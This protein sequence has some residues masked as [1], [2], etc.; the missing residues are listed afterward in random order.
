MSMKMTFKDEGFDADGK[1]F[2]KTFMKAKG[3]DVEFLSDNTMDILMNDRVTVLMKDDETENKWAM[4]NYD[5]SSP[6]FYK[7]VPTVILE[8]AKK[9]KEDLMLARKKKSEE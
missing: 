5:P 4:L 3:M 1:E 7:I 2:M 8:E 9:Y 6:I